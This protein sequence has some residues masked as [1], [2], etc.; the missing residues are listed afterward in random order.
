MITGT[1]EAWYPNVMLTQCVKYVVWLGLCC[2]AVQ[3]LDTELVVE[4]TRSCVAVLFGTRAETGAEVQSSGCCVGAD[5]LI[6]TTAHQITGVQNIEARFYDGRTAKLEV[7]E[8]D[9]AR[10]IALLRA[11][12]PLPGAARIGDAATLRGGA[13]LI[14]IA[15]PRSL[16]FSV[17][18]GTVSNT[19][20]TL[21]DYPVIQAALRAAPGSSGG[22]VFDRTGALVGMIIG[23]LRD[24]DWITAIN[25]VNNAYDML[26]RHGLLAAA[27][28]LTGEVDGELMPARGATQTDLRAIEAYNRGV[29]A[30]AVD[31]KVAAY[32]EAVRLLPEFYMAWFN[33][34]VAQTAGGNSA[35]A[36][37]AYQKALELEPGAVE[38]QRNL[39]R[40][41]LRQQ[42]LEEAARA[43]QTALELAPDEAQS[44]ND[45]GEVL[46][47]M[48]RNDE[49]V[50]AFE[51]ALRLRQDYP[52]A[53]Y[54]LG[55][56]YTNMNRAAEAVRHFE[57]YLAL[58]PDAEDAG[59][60]RAWIEELRSQS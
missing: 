47:Q 11:D 3:A 27:P 25:P 43:F 39:G 19:N 6:L 13:D 49:A 50:R 14:S 38:V 37:D 51:T 21:R 9:A 57:Q 34:A 41:Y 35:G 31:Q 48:K 56:T 17:V 18:T 46:R 20:R 26:R 55:L 32:A 10:E 44:H 4:Q 52:A 40:L 45:L 58:L 59:Q 15:A 8:I 2:S 60:V 42:R 54:N 24:E 23:K 1:G 5:G 53:H 28:D 30:G 22:P 36:E 7:V 29:R 16:D 12:A 33:L